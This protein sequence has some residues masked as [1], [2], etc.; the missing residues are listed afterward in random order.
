MDKF[1]VIVAGGS[2]LRM[3]HETPKQFL[4]VGEVPLLI[5]TI[6]AFTKAFSDLSVVLVLPAE[7][8]QK[9][10]EMVSSFMPDAPVQFAPGGK[11]RFD[12]VRSG[13]GLVSADSIVFVHDA[14][15]CL[16]SPLLIRKCY[17][18]A[19][20]LGSAVPVVPLKDSIRKITAEGSEVQNRELLRAVQTPQTFR[21]ET[22]L[23][24]FQTD[25]QESFT[26]EATVVEYS[27]GSISLID[28]EEANIKITYPSDLLLAEQFFNNPKSI[29]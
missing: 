9:G 11:T 1:A 3:G 5:H 28:G 25:Y 18:Q 8:M 15:R 21:A 16:V 20:V 13:L 27:G 29:S 6:R 23:K 22:L 4:P 24:A 12:S 14:V 7:H 17:E 2:G 26:D 19:L 10:Q